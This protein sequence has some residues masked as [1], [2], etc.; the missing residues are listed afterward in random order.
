MAP[1]QRLKILGRESRDI[2]MLSGLVQ[3]AIFVP[4]DMTI[5]DEKRRFVAVLNRFQWD[6]AARLARRIRTPAPLMQS[7]KTT[8]P[9]ATPAASPR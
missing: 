1:N 4:T 5:E 6:R 7:F 2:V 3:D 8:Y 9:A